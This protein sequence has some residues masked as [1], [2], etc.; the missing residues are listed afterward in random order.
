[1]KLSVVFE[2]LLSAYSEQNWWPVTE[3]GELLPTYKKR[4]RLTEQQKFEVCIGAILTQNTD[5]KNAMKALEQL[6]KAKMLSC[7]ALAAARQPAI[8]KL[9]RSSGYFNQKAKEVSLFAKYL[10]ANY[11][12]S[13]EKLFEK[14]LEELRQ[15]LLSLHGIGPETADDIILYAAGKPSFVV[16]AYTRRFVERF[17]GKKMDY[18]EAK[19]FFEGQLP[20]DAQLF[21]E[22]HAL[23]VEHGKRNCGKKPVCGKCFLSENCF[24]QR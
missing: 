13:V 8:A 23:L 9:I 1:M 4:D 18:D 21:N 7:N 11:S 20:K 10:R 12:C 15:E 19:Q 3:P 24:F 6:N 17:F 22:F 5:W 14:P 2:K 16:D